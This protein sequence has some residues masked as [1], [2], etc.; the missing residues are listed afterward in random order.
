MRLSL[1]LLANCKL[2]SLASRK[3]A[4]DPGGRGDASRNRKKRAPSPSSLVEVNRTEQK[5]GLPSPCLSLTFAGGWGVWES[6]CGPETLGVP[7][8]PTSWV[9]VS[10]SRRLPLPQ[11]TLP[12]KRERLR[13]PLT[14]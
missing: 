12:F 6:G 3:A 14:D 5:C 9:M 10:S 13:R 1:Q 4:G 7:Q 8:I 11:L 2:D